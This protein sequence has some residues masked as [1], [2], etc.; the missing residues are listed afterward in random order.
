[1][2]NQPDLTTI[3]RNQFAADQLQAQRFDLLAESIE[4]MRAEVAALRERL[5]H[6]GPN[7]NQEQSHD[8]NQSGAHS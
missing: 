3:A 6:E 2:Q 4:Q 5:N 1:M 8:P 7:P